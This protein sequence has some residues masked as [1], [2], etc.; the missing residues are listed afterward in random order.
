MRQMKV[1]WWYRI[2]V[3]WWYQM[4]VLWWYQIKVEGLRSAAAKQTLIR[5]HHSTFI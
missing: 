3:L 2:K 1:L 5:Y 4:K